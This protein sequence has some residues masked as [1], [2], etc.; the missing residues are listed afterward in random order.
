MTISEERLLVLQRE[1]EEAFGGKTKTKLQLSLR[2]HRR[3]LT[4]LLTDMEGFLE[5]LEAIPSGR[6][7]DK[8][9]DVLDKSEAK[10]NDIEYGYNVLTQLDP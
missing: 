4:K 7:A 9:T 1:R 2:T 6:C 10:V 5:N 8:L 3:V